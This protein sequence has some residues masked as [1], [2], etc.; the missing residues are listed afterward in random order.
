MIDFSRNYF[1]LFGLPARFRVDAEALDDA[2]RALQA[3][4]HPDRHVTGNDTERRI[5]LQSSARVN[6]AYRALRDPA[7]RAAHLLALRGIAAQG[8]SDTPLAAKFL[9]K[10]LERREQA[11]DA[12]EARDLG[13]LELL[14]A[15][16]GAE[17]I[18][19]ETAL[20]LLL[21]GAGAWADAR[22]AVGEYKFLAKM[23]ADIDA[24]IGDL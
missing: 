18:E 15:E 16:V 17:M 5:A 13:A 12:A 22:A 4:V 8:E 20:A 21:D 1:E 9:E 2:Y 24:M 6:E 14:A 11:S 10:Q 23:M 19:R 7:E 3:R